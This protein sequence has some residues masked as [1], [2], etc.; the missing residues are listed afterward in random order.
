[1]RR[2]A[3]DRV[4]RVLYYEEAV[5]GC[6]VLAAKGMLED[7]GTHRFRPMSQNY[8]PTKKKTTFH[9]NELKAPT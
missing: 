1:M 5:A 2:F 6:A 7:G 8:T 4:W 9:G 3:A